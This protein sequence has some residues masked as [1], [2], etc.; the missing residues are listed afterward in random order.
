MDLGQEI[1]SLANEGICCLNS[2]FQHARTQA[3]K[4]IA[5]CIPYL[6]KFINFGRNGKE[7]EEEKEEVRSYLFLREIKIK[8]ERLSEDVMKFLGSIGG[9]C[10][11]LV[12]NK[13][14][15]YISWDYHCKVD[16]DVLMAG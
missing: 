10:H 15:D 9:L 1:I 3:E 5:D 4:Y 7:E 14:N 16:L 2:I 12:A 8:K 13:T 11:S 6:E